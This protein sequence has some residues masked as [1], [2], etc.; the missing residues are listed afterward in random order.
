MTVSRWKF[1]CLSHLKVRNCRKFI[2]CACSVT[3]TLSL[4]IGI[5]QAVSNHIVILVVGRMFKAVIEISAVSFPISISP[6]DLR[7]H[8]GY[9]Y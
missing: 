3:K 7:T 8:L 5:F 1:P 4:S 9:C 6:L 2:L